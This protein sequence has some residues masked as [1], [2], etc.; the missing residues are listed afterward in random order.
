MSP[1]AV[2]DGD[3]VGVV[4]RARL[5]DLEREKSSWMPGVVGTRVEGVT[6]GAVSDAMGCARLHTRW[7]ETSGP[8]PLLTIRSFPCY[9]TRGSPQS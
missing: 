3:G 7:V 2:A 4:S 6:T 8:K 5:R 1:T 9:R